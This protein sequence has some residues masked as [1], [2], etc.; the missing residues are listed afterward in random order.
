MAETTTASPEQMAVQ[1]AR[2]DLADPLIELAESTL[3]VARRVDFVRHEVDRGPP[4]RQAIADVDALM[5]PLEEMLA[6]VEVVIADMDGVLQPTHDA[7]EGLVAL[8][9][10]VLADV[11][12]ETAALQP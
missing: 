3:D 12:E 6:D 7:V 4:M 9:R 1:H 5:G 10:S 11:A 2:E 8:S